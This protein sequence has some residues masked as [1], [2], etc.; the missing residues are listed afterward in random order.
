MF[1]FFE[2]V[3]ATGATISTVATLSTKADII[4]ANSAMATAA[5]LTLG[6]FPLLNRQVIRA[7]CCQ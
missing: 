5:H 7:F 1:N 6:I 4:P 2:S 3:S